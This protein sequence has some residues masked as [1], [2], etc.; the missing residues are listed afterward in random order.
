MRKIPKYS[1]EPENSTSGYIINYLN[2]GV[3]EVNSCQF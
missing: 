1:L 3:G 2:D